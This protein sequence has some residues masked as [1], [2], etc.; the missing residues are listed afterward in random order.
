MPLLA[1]SN[2]VVCC[3]GLVCMR[4]RCEGSGKGGTA[5]QRQVLLE[6][7]A[8][9]LRTYQVHHEGTEGTGGRPLGQVVELITAL[10]LRVHGLSDTPPPTGE[11]GG[12]PPACLLAGLAD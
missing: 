7:A 12:R 6:A 9:R 5:Q 10:A 2:R 8:R 4:G 11:E 3:W 1:L